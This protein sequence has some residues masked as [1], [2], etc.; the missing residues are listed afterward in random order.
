M[1]CTPLNTLNFVIFYKKCDKKVLVPL[2][3]SINSLKHGNPD[4]EL[5]IT[6]PGTFIYK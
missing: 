2:S 3:W 1:S 4:L 5:H 6:L